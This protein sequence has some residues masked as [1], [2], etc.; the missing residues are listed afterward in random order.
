[1]NMPVNL[2]DLSCSLKLA[3]TR[4]VRMFEVVFN[5]QHVVEIKIIHRHEVQ[6]F[7]IIAFKLHDSVY[8]KGN[9]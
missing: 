9:V 4:T 6:S 8:T 1:M 7:I 2:H 3:N 5:N